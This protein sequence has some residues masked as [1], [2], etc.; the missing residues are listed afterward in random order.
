M[1]PLLPMLMFPPS[2]EIIVLHQSPGKQTGMC[3]Y[4]CVCV[5]VVCVCL[6]VCLL[7]GGCGCV[8][9]RV[10]VCARAFLCQYVCVC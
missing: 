2:N 10:S 3:V 9:V 5:C 4:V 7:V 1:L 8:C 6:C